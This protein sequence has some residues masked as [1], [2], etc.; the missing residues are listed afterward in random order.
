VSQERLAQMIGA[1]RES[2]NKALAAL[3]RRGLVKRAGKRY[4]VSNIEELRSRAR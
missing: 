4:L 2:V 1:T 3:T